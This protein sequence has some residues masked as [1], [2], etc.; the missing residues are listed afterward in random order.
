MANKANLVLKNENDKKKKAKASAC[1]GGSGVA[2]EG[3]GRMGEER[4]VGSAAVDQ[5]E[6]AELSPQAQ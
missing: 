5:V 3:M 2:L 6:E 1:S 4:I